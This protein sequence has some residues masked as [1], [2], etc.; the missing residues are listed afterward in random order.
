VV[1][2]LSVLQKRT[3]Y[4]HQPRSLIPD[5][6]FQKKRARFPLTINVPPSERAIQTRGIMRNKQIAGIIIAGLFLMLPVFLSAQT[7]AELEAIMGSPAVN[8][9][10][11]ARFVLASAGGASAGVSPSGNDFEQALANGWFPKGSVADESIT[12]GKLS[13]LMMKAFNIRGGMMYSLLPGPRYAF[14]NMVSRSLIQGEA[15]PSMTVSGERF[16]RIL[17]NVLS[18]AGEEI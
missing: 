5:P 18:K 3:D 16:L 17:G 6:H 11:A 14:R 7:A 1:S 10:Q 13:F 12:L 2:N 8:C 9:G 15:D 4:K